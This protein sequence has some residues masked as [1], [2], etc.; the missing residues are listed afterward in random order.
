MAPTEKPTKKKKRKAEP[1]EGGVMLRSGSDVRYERRFEPKTAAVAVL[2]VLGMSIG[3]VLCGAGT[4]G[5]WL[6]A[7]GLGPHPYAPYLLAGGAL[8]LLVV[9]IFGQR[10]PRP[11][12]VGDAG[13][14]VEKEPTEMER[15]AWHEVKRV[16]LIGD[17]LTFQAPGRQLSFPLSAHRS[18]AHYAVA[19]AVERIPARVDDEAKAKLSGASPDNEEGKRVPLDPA[20][21]AGARCKQSDRVV[22][23]EGDARLCGRCGEVYHKDEVPKRCLSCDAKL[24]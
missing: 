7:E 4:Y 2:S 22:A 15:I 11:V 5:Q 18:A 8:P 16:L 20:Q 3:A 6:R 12:R 1:T 14:A 21:V 13:V 24:R 23:F 10:V 9:A 17:M 19:Q